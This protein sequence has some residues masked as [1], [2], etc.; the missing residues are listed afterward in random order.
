MAAYSPQ[1]P[2]G[3]CNAHRVVPAGPVR[4]L[5]TTA[6]TMVSGIMGALYH[7]ERTGQGQMVS[8]SLLRTGIYSIGMDVSTRVG[9]GRVGAAPSRKKPQNPLMNSYCAGD[10][11]WFWI[12]G[13]ESERHWPGIVRALGDPS[14]LEDE[15]FATPRERRRNAEALVSAIDALASR[16][17]RQEW[18]AIFSEHDVC[19]RPSIV[20]DVVVD[21][22]AIASGASVHVPVHPARG[23]GRLQRGPPRRFQCDASAQPACRR[24]SA[25][26]PMH[27]LP[28]SA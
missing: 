11:K 21:P 23:A 7:R 9:L 22:Q 19:G 12:V 24:A 20:D 26:I 3:A 8:T 1:R 6:I 13:A 17:T 4:R 5:A 16:H 27:C 14:L 15:R 2:G 10:D 28:S 18:A 25:P